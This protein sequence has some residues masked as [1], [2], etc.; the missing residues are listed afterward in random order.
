MKFRLRSAL[1]ARRL[2][3]REICRGA[4]ARAPHEISLAVIDE[5]TTF[6]KK[7]NFPGAP[8]EPVPRGHAP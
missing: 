2:A 3:G 4:R 6:G 8:R 5:L 7:R 1:S